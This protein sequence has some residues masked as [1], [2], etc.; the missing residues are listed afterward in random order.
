VLTVGDD[1]RKIAAALLSGAGTWLLIPSWYRALT[2]RL[3]PPRLREDFG[4]PYGQLEHRKTERALA[5]LRHVYPRVPACLRHVGP[6]H[7]ARAR[8]AGHHS[9]G[10]ATQLLNRLWI[11]QKSIAG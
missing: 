3:L 2:A 6:Y 8:L 7:E 9:P 10:P 1:A 11:G 4:L 5:V